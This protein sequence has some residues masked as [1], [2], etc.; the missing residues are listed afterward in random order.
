MS[1]RLLAVPFLFSLT[2]CTYQAQR[3]AQSMLSRYWR[4]STGTS[5]SGTHIFNVRPAQ[6]FDPGLVATCSSLGGTTPG[7][8]RQRPL[9]HARGLHLTALL[10]DI[11][12]LS[13]G[14]SMYQLAPRPIL[15]TWNNECDVKRVVSKRCERKRMTPCPRHRERWPRDAGA[16]DVLPSDHRVLLSSPDHALDA[17]L[18]RRPV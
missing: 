8:I 9:F 12:W 11:G 1:R 5:R 2:I 17:V 6:R 18:V 13:S 16:A 15:S 14:L 3:A 10:P 4:P 7:V